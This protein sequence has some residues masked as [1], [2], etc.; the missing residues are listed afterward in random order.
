MWSGGVSCIEENRKKKWKEK[1]TDFK[2]NNEAYERKLKDIN[3]DL[4]RIQNDYD[5]YLLRIKNLDPMLGV[6]ENY[7]SIYKENFQYIEEAYT[8]KQLIDLFKL[9]DD[10]GALQLFLLSMS[11]YNLGYFDNVKKTAAQLIEKYP[12]SNY[13]ES[14]SSIVNFMP[15]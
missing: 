8:R 12:S 9:D 3:T 11:Y 14:I 2:G 4:K 7:A 10:K 13:N 6:L 5:L 15:R 1:A